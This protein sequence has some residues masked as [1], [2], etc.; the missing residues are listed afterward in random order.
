MHDI[1]GYSN[2]KQG[3]IHTHMKQ[4]TMYW[5]NQVSWSWAVQYWPQI[6]IN[7]WK[8]QN[9]LSFHLKCKRSICLCQFWAVEHTLLYSSLLWATLPT[10]PKPVAPTITFPVFLVASRL[11]PY[12]RTLEMCIPKDLT[13]FYFPIHKKEILPTLHLGKLRL[14]DR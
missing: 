11:V 6:T 7:Q 5:Q 9:S 13:I 12:K 2:Q 14:G 10:S 1:P 4:W 3:I 8:F